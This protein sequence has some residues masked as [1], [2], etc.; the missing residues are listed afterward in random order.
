MRLMTRGAFRPDIVVCVFFTVIAAIFYGS[1]IWSGLISLTDSK[2][3]PSFHFVGFDQYVRLWNTPRWLTACSNLVVFGGLYIVLSLLIGTFLA[4]CLDQK[5][6]M[7][8]LLRTIYL[9]P[10]ALSLIVTGLA[11]R[12]LLDPETGI[13]HFVRA[14][15]WESFHFD[16]LTDPHRAIYT[17]V[18]AAIW[19]SVGFIMIIMLAGLRGVDDDIWK[20]IHVEGIPR[21]RAYL[22][23]ILPSL[24][25]MIASCV[26]LLTAD[27]IRSYDLVIAL[28]KGGPGFST[29]L[30]AKFA[31]DQ[32]FGR[33]NIGLG[34]AASIIML[35]IVL[36]L[37]APY[38]Y[39]EFRKKP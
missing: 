10:L 1:L 7:E 8:G 26:V 12:W 9:Y 25:P 39:S 32:F 28:T 19:H 14:T 22:H 20:A 34:S 5:V 37:L 36:V 33:A 11:W 6:R 2:L 13:Q 29:D 30:P 31:V 15:G 27:V 16:W 38:F 24:K 17:L 21:W 35:V 4:I 3:L 18:I 23:V